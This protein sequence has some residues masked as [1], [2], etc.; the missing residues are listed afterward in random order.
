ME[1]NRLL[2]LVKSGGG[3]ATET[4][5][6][7]DEYSWL[8][9]TIRGGGRCEQH[10]L[11]PSRMTGT[12]LIESQTRSSSCFSNHGHSK[13]RKRHYYLNSP[14]ENLNL[15]RTH[16]RTIEIVNADERQTNKIYLRR[17]QNQDRKSKTILCNFWKKEDDPNLKRVE[18]LGEAEKSGS[19][20][21]RRSQM[22]L[23]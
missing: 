13:Q 2:R 6:S 16:F 17:A 14:R 4:D 22:Q 18:P 5:Q 10:C 8:V 12:S 15:I 1:N 7:E 20:P 23:G 3:G 11:I 21:L 9:F 19:D